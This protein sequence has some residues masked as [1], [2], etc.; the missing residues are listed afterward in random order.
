MDDLSYLLD[1]VHDILDVLNRVEGVHSGHGDFQLL[2][3]KVDFIYYIDTSVLLGTKPLV[4]SIRHCIR[5]PSG[6]FSV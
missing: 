4:D 1:C 5:D 6:V 2:I 3:C